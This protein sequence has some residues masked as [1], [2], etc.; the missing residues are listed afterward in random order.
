M[1][2]KRKI[3]HWLL[4]LSL[5]LVIISSVSSLSPT[6]FIEEHQIAT[7]APINNDFLEY[8]KEPSLKKWRKYSET[9]YAF[10]LIPSPH[11]FSYFKD[12]PLVKIQNLP[13]SYD[14]R[15]EGKLTPIKNQGQCGSCWAFASYGSL[16]S[17]LM[18]SEARDFSEQNLIDRHGFDWEPCEGG[19]IFMSTAY[20][21]RWSGPVNEKDDPYVF[22]NLDGFKT[23]KHIQEVVCVPRRSDSLDNNLIKQAVMT[24]GAVYASMYYSNYCYN[25]IY[26]SYYNTTEEEGAH[27]VAIVG[28]DDN[29]DKNKFNT[30]PP[31]NGAFIVRNS[32]G[33]NWGENGYFY[34]SYY[35]NYFAKKEISAAITAEPP[36]CY[37]VIYQYDKLGWTWSLGYG[38][39]TA[40]FANMFT[41]TSSYPLLAVSFYA[42]ASSNDYE[43]YIYKNVKDGQPRS[44]ILARKQT[45]SLNSPGYFTVP[46]KVGVSLVPGQKFS[47][48]VKLKTKNY[49]Y[50]LPIEYPHKGYSSRA[51]ANVGESFISNNGETWSDLHTSWDGR[52]ANTNV[53]LKAFAGLPPVYPP[54]N[55]T[56]QRLENNYI[57]FIEYINRLNW[58]ANPDNRIEIKAYR[59]YRMRKGVSDESYELVDEFDASI[60][61]YDHRG[62]K[63]DELYSYRITSVDEYGRES[64]PTEVSN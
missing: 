6:I 45:G 9:G 1:K 5:V 36:T 52:F 22:S 28:W 48:V 31:G 34:V 32:W 64:E 40:W 20:L 26:K 56:L 27:A 3:W 62:L 7:P 53:C 10:G 54:K 4:T 21:A 50:P 23:R 43:I 29:F 8:L 37:S 30:I 51:R 59:L 12:L 14:L 24:Y 25:A 19:D 49:N 35:D 16:E 18:P 13:A 11:D 60:F 15:T 57:F 33:K 42:A 2:F 58:E 63:K 44:G 55:F 46:L 41:A 39:D 61:A 47:V 38:S 17:F